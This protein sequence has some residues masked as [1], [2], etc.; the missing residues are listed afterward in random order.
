MTEQ[1]KLLI[2]DDDTGLL[3]LLQKFFK[4][5]DFIVE[6]AT[7]SKDA[8]SIF[9]EKKIDLVILD[10][11]IHHENG[12]DLC[13]RIRRDNDIPVIM[14][15]CSNKD[16]HHLLCFKYGVDDYMTK[17]CSMEVLLAHVNAIVRR[18]YPQKF[19]A[20]IYQFL[21]WQLNTEKQILTDPNDEVVPLTNGLYNLLLSFVEH[22]QQVLTR[23]QLLDIVA[24]YTDDPF[25]RG[26]DIQLTRLRKK[27][28]DHYKNATFIKTIYTKGYVFLPAVKRIH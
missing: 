13:K 27:L 22:P 26:I 25:A 6:I 20:R 7:S 12:A 1:Y 23:H 10:L 8:L 19:N 28:G 15:T 3:T 17:P 4:Q 2:V 14:L 21:N 16:K 11:H 5:H 18:S 9:N 24:G